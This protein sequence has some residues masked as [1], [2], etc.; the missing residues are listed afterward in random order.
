MNS[1]SCSA[2]LSTLYERTQVS[3]HNWRISCAHV[4]FRNSHN[5]TFLKIEDLENLKRR[6]NHKSLDLI[7]WRRSEQSFDCQL[8]AA[9]QKRSLGPTRVLSVWS[10]STFRTIQCGVEQLAFVWTAYQSTR[11]CLA[12]VT[13]ARLRC[14][15]LRVWSCFVAES[16]GEIKTPHLGHSLQTA[17][18]MS[19]AGRSVWVSVHTV[20]VCIPTPVSACECVWE[21][22]F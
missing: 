15:C 21:T 7:T 17:R 22:S 1:K 14:L 3:L 11:Q 18:A 2:S 9:W 8:L 20:S 5:L 10:V 4:N 13:E 12:H 16:V 6:G 19:P